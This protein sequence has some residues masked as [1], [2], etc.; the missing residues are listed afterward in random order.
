M[1]K[2]VFLMLVV[3]LT[4]AICHNSEAKDNSDEAKIK[5]VIKQAFIT[6]R[7]A[8]AKQVQC[9]DRVEEGAKSSSDAFAELEEYVNNK[10]GYMDK[11]KSFIYVKE[12]N[13][14]AAFAGMKKWHFKKFDFKSIVVNGD[15]AVVEVDEYVEAT[16]TMG[17]QEYVETIRDD[18]DRVIETK[19]HSAPEHDIVTPGGD[20]HMISLER[21]N[22]KWQIVWDEY[23]FLPEYQP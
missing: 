22:N 13:E 7:K 19:R 3:C 23:H 6:E 5:A 10:K 8:Y 2:K 21:I 1:F 4:A 17:A 15:T 12:G 18:K 20:K 14:K 16:T 11:L 9:E